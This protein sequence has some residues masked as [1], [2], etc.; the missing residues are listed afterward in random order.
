[1]IDRYITVGDKAC[2]AKIA[3]LNRNH[4]R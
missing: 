3:H 4:R 1:L 2:G